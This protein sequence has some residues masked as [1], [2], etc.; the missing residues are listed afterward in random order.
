GGSA[1][2]HPFAVK[3]FADGV[4]GNYTALLLEPYSV[5]SSAGHTGT[6]MY[7]PELLSHIATLLDREGCQ[8]HVHAIGDAAVRETL[9]AYDAALRAN[10]ARD[11][12]HQICHLQLVHPSDVPRFAAL[13]VVA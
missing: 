11:S 4:V 1:R 9:D 2:I 10:G 7:E 12:R 13:G 8:I 6:R 3:L 5:G